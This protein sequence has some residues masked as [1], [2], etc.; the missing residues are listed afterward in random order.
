MLR[1]DGST[2]ASEVYRRRGQ[3]IAVSRACDPHV[4]RQ[5]YTLCACCQLCL[6]FVIQTPGYTPS[7][8]PYFGVELRCGRRG[9]GRAD[10]WHTCA[11][12]YFVSQTHRLL[13]L[14]WHQRGAAF[15]HP[16]R[17]HRHFPPD[18][19]LSRGDRALSG[20]CVGPFA[21]LAR[22]VA[23]VAS[24]TCK[25]SVFSGACVQALGILFACL[26]ADLLAAWQTSSGRTVR[27]FAF[28]PETQLCDL[29]QR[30]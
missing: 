5:R 15:R 29:S 28:F 26:T 11:T 14:L 24:Q 1:S 2:S 13:R 30:T 10:A 12:Y 7:T 17:S 25:R 20:S 8:S 4:K 3:P 18:G 22:D 16:S 27:E 9:S 23:D 21:V 6:I 19:A